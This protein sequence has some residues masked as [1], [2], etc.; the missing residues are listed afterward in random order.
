[1]LA[2]FESAAV[3]SKITAEW[4]GSCTRGVFAA[5]CCVFAGFVDCHALSPFHA[6]I[7]LGQYKFVRRSVQESDGQL[8][9]DSSLDGAEIVPK[10]GPKTKRTERI[11]VR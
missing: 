7:L 10:P 6:G 11:H 8:A 5:Y 9:S 3:P 4:Y 2:E 1:M